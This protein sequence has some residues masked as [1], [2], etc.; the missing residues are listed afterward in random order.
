MVLGDWIDKVDRELLN[1]LIKYAEERFPRAKGELLLTGIG[2]LYA[3]ASEDT[4]HRLLE[5]RDRVLKAIYDYKWELYMAYSFG[6]YD[7][8]GEN[9]YAEMMDALKDMDDVAFELAQVLGQIY[10]DV[11]KKLEEERKKSVF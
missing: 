1:I 11:L 7:L 4:R 3:H 8:L 2:R 6:R 5:L 10:A 9:Q